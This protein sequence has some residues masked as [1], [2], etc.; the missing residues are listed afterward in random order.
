MTKLISSIFLSVIC[1]QLSAQT[2]GVVSYVEDKAAPIREHNVDFIT[3]TLD[4]NFIPEAGN[5]SGNANYTFKAIQPKVDSVFL[6]GP[7][8]LIQQIQ[9]DN[10]A[11]RFRVD[12]AGIT[13]FFNPPLIRNIEHKLVIEYDATPKKGIYFVGWNNAITDSDT[14]PTIIR[15]QIWTQGQ[16]TDNR[17]WIPSYDGLNDKLITALNITFN[18]KYTVVSNGELSKVTDNKNG[19]KTWN[20]AMPNPHS[21]YLVMVAIGKYE[22]LDYTSKNGMTSRQY[23]Y[24]GTKAI[25]T[26]TYAYSAEMMDFLV[27]ET[28]TPYPWTTY[29][30]V[31]V[32]E[33]L[34][35]AME[36]TT[37]TI[38]SDFYFQDKR[39]FPDKN[40]VDI[41][42][43]ELTHQWFGDYVT[44]WSGTSHWLQESFATYY[45]K[46]FRQKISGDDTYY[47]KRREEM[48]SAFDADNKNVLP[49]AHT[50]AGSQRVYQK[51]S[52]VLDMLRYVVGDEQF[53]I[54]IKEFLARYPYQNVASKDFEMQ[55][56]RS[57]GIDVEWFF[58]QWI[59]RGGYPIYGVNYARA[60]NTVNV[61]IKQK[62][63]QSETIGLFKM[64]VHVQVHYMD[65]SFEDKLIWIEN[66]LTTV[67]FTLPENGKVAFV[68]F[69]PNSMVYAKVDF[70]KSYDELKFQAFNAP[71]MMDRYDAV[72]LMREIDIETKRS[73]LITLFNKEIFYGIK[74]EIIAQL[75]NDDNKK[76]IGLLKLALSD[77]HPYVRRAVI[78]NIK[79]IA[80]SM[81]DELELML[82]DSNYLNIEI[83]LNQLCK[84]NPGKTEKYLFLT[85]D[86][87]GSTNNVRISWLE[88]ANGTNKNQNI[89]EL[90][91]FS[92]SGYEFRTRNSAFVAL[93]DMNYCAEAVV[94]NLFNALVS[95]NHRLST[96]AR[97]ALTKFKQ[98]PEYNE[99][100]KAYYKSQNWTTWQQTRIGTIKD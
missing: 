30:N 12:S 51:G 22:Y 81:E 42:A 34:Y 38:F 61:E 68:L 58:D 60:E 74:S 35:G 69:D 95:G 8:I 21:L 36:N 24:P 84:L 23:Y 11:T 53:K 73:D 54:A 3:L 48:N 16:G 52:I 90:V 19:T 20:Y 9:L 10:K 47:W 45:A 39:T 92:S 77:N 43:H 56:M 6:D 17:F 25:A 18:D 94:A 65:G 62:Q 87:I 41:N 67:S 78:S 93:V 99:M 32:Q 100:I 57:M 15:K 76:S 14:D 7:G 46:K 86:I 89:N 96:P 1:L 71:N 88:I 50:E 64:P 82:S 85:K 49:V 63:Q 5:L 2:R 31:P 26:E 29:A 70:Q 83:A 55:F 27:D 72:V 91:N 33:F 80:G 37:A 4:L 28:G 79:T 40:Y 44:A 59:Y 75:S 13:V 97:N 98:T 66:A